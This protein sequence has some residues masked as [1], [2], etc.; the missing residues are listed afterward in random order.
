MKGFFKGLRGGMKLF[1]HDIAG[2]VNTILLSVAYIIGVGI[3][4]LIAKLSGKRFLD[5][6]LNP[7]ARTYWQDTDKNQHE[8]IYRQF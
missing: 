5:L 7:K 6:R 4:A 1:G 8:G 2:L 3:T